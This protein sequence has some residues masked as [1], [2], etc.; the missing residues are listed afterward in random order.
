MATA[1]QY[2]LPLPFLAQPVAMPRASPRKRRRRHAPHVQEQLQL[3]LLPF[4]EEYEKEHATR[5]TLEECLR[6][7]EFVLDRSL[8]S[9]ADVRVGTNTL[10]EIREWLVEPFRKRRLRAFSFQA[11]CLAAGLD[12]EVIQEQA[13]IQI[14]K[15]LGMSQKH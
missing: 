2:Q 10:E 1:A 6:L 8:S 15:R 12:P 7:H 5:V 3:S 14:D 11:C 4:L 13:L 9:I